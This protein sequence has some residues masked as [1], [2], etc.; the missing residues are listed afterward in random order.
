[1]H[2]R[3][4]ILLGLVCSLAFG[5]ELQ[6]IPESEIMGQASTE[7]LGFTPLP[8]KK[9]LSNSSGVSVQPYQNSDEYDTSFDGS[10]ETGSMLGGKRQIPAVRDLRDLELEEAKVGWS[11]GIGTQYFLQ[12]DI[13]PIV[14]IQ[15]AIGQN[16]SAGLLFTT[17]GGFDI[18]GLT[19]GNPVQLTQGFFTL[20]LNSDRQFRGLWLQGGAGATLYKTQPVGAE[21]T[22]TVL[23][24]PTL[25]GT[26]GWRWKLPD[27][28]GG[29]DSV[30][31][32]ASAGI[33]IFY[34]QTNLNGP[35]QNILVMLP[36]A[37]FEFNFGW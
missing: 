21:T 26:A 36:V 34:G 10:R 25:S 30:S 13:Y 4:L 2:S 31:F 11:F 6:P 17:M 24:F 15:M 35:T 33:N 3:F 29:D 12:R 7:E 22:G 19:S 32:S 14:N 9:T 37:R 23:Y 5:E 18:I 20:N 1:M 27:A 16:V 28:N 8:Q